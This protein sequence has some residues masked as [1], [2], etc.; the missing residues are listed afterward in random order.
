MVQGKSG[1]KALIV[2]L[3]V[4]LC[5]C[6]GGGKGG[7]A[8][9]GTSADERPSERADARDVAAEDATTQQDLAFGDL[10][11]PGEDLAHDGGPPA[12]WS[13]GPPL[14]YPVEK[15]LVAFIANPSSDPIGDALERGELVVPEAPGKDSYG[16]TWIEVL[17]GPNGSLGFTGFGMF[18]AVA[19]LRFDGSSGVIVRADQVFRIFLGPGRQP[20]PGSYEGGGRSRVPLRLEGDDYLVVQT[21]GGS[22]PAVEV[23]TTAAE[24]AFNLDDVTAPDLVLGETG[25]TWLGIPV[26]NFTA[27]PLFKL[28]AKVLEDE[29]F[30]STVTEYPALAPLAATQVAFRLR[31]KRTP[32]KA[33]ETIPVR[34]RLEAEGLLWAYEAV[35]E[36]RS[37]SP[38]VPYRITRRSQVDGSVQYYAVLRPSPYD[39]D[40]QYGLVLTLHG[41]GVEALSQVSAYSPKDFAWIVGPTNRRPFGYNWE[42]WGRIDATEALEHA[43]DLFNIDRERVYVTGHSMG[44]HGTWQLGV[45]FPGKFAVIAPSAGWISYYTYSGAKK[46]T[47]PIGRA[48]ASSDTLAYASNLA[49]RAVYVLHGENDNNVPVSEAETMFNALQGT[50]EELDMHIEPGAGHWWDGDKSPGVDCVDWPPIFELMRN[51]KLDIYETDFRFMT[52]SPSVTATHSFVTILAED[53]PMRDCVVAAERKGEKVIITTENVRTMSIKGD[54]LRSKGF[55]AVEINGVEIQVPYS[56][57]EFGKAALKVGKQHGPFNQVFE[58][59]FCFVVADNDPGRFLEIASYLVSSWYVHGNGQACVV[60][61]SQ[62]SSEVLKDYNLVYVGIPSDLVPVPEKFPVQWN[63]STVNV[64]GQSFSLVALAVVFPQESRLNGALFATSG[65]EHLL[66]WHMPF[67]PNSAL[68]DYTVWSESGLRAAGFFDWNWQ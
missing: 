10:A 7:E 19:R 51:R 42:D 56:E 5:A 3:F 9:F 24:V 67:R 54:V 62:S 32:D 15:W 55:S 20:Q 30:D 28:K 2:L 66:F 68:P 61:L 41:A 27:N 22:N 47:G 60:P 21:W 40:K 29:M 58:R 52:P 53:D 46:P 50:V 26:L 36:L 34:V 8:D 65:Q 25:E 23:W 12:V 13:G 64:R 49:K 6:S 35:V 1:I 39:P 4:A 57:F 18:Y 11:E 63:F 17:P 31:L 48:R 37:V 59:P 43:A 16:V 45:L 14:P 44:G 33:G 38:Y